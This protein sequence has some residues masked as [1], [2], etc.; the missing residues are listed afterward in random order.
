MLF[1]IG[2]ETINFLKDIIKIGFYVLSFSFND[3]IFAAT[4]WIFIWVL[5]NIRENSKP[6]TLIY[7]L[8]FEKGVLKKNLP[9][10]TVDLALRTWLFKRAIS[11]F[12]MNVV[13]MVSEVKIRPFVLQPLKHK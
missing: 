6:A 11:I 9:S 12:N 4:N 1:Y 2:Q 7:N 3:S 5:R 10:K 8:K 13:R